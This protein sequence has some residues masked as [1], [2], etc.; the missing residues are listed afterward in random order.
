MIRRE[1]TP[2]P[3]T[4]TVPMRKEQ[5]ALVEEPDELEVLISMT[6]MRGSPATRF[7]PPSDAVEMMTSEEG[8]T[9]PVGLTPLTPGSGR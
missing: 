6:L 3:S 8:V 1:R 9:P 2:A 4:F 7:S 5:V